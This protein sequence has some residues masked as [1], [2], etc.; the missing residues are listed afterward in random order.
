[1]S[2]DICIPLL[3]LGGLLLASSGWGSAT[4]LNSYSAQDGPQQ[5]TVWPQMSRHPVLN[6]EPNLYLL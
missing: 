6:Q 3:G 4:L 1:M 5:G 2:G